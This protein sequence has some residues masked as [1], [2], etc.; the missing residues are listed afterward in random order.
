MN[1]SLKLSK[2]RKIPNKITSKVI[3][4]YDKGLWPI[5][6]VKTAETL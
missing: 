2:L 3:V 6:Y 1:T 4:K 5:A